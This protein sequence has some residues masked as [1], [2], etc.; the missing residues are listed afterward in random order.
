MKASD[1]ANTNLHTEGE[2]SFAICS[3]CFAITPTTYRRRDVS[4]GDGSGQV[5]DI[6]VSVCDI[7]G[8]IVAIPAESASAI[9][10]ARPKAR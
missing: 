2:K 7:C 4:F 8:S 1:P 6:L 5:K 9:R 3:F 10:E